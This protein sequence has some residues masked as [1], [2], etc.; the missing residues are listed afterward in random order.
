MGCCDECSEESYADGWESGFAAALD[1]LES[2][3][4]ARPEV[5][6]A[7]AMGYEAVMEIIETMKG[8]PSE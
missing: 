7:E 2:R 1:E 8:G 3:I 6:R 5:L 4:Q